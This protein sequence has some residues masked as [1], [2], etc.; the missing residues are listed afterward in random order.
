M[1]YDEALTFNEFASRP[2]YY[3]L[4]FYPD[5]NNHLLNTLLMHIAFVA[6]GQPAVGAATARLLAGVL[7]VPATYWLA[8]LL[9]GPSAAVLAAALVAASSYM[10]EYS[11]NA[12]GYTL[13]ALCFVMLA[14]VG[15][16]GARGDSLL[17][18]CWRA[19]GALGA[20]A[21]P[22]MLYG[23]V[24]RRRLGCFDAAHL[25]RGTLVASG[26]V[27]GLVSILAV[28]AGADHLGPDKLAA[29]RFVVPLALGGVPAELARLAGSTWAF[30]NRDVPLAAG[31]AAAV[32]LL[33]HG[34]SSSCAAL[35]AA[36]L[37]APLVCLAAG[38]SFSASRR[39]S[40]C[41]CFCCRSISRS[42][43]AGLARFVD[44]RLL[45]LVFGA[46]LGYIMLSSG[47][48]LRSTETGAFPDAE[49]VTRTLAPRLA[50]D[51][52]VMT[53]LPASLPELQYYFPRAGLPTSVLVRAPDDAQ[54]VWVIA[55]PG[56]AP[57]PTAA[58]PT[59]IE[60][61]RFPSA[62]L[63]ELKAPC[64][65]ALTASSTFSRHVGLR[66]AR[67]RLAA[68]VGPQQRHLVRV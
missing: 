20:Y 38:C 4:S 6:A 29:N 43:A 55:A 67:K 32:R 50:P 1:R 22:T 35:R 48:I 2:L 46:V 12:R 13:Q 18:C 56:S 30:W 63:F 37:A 40:A 53:Q 42:P 14:L 58:W 28:P 62:T 52:A 61:Q 47:S 21:V 7:L 31:R 24:D 36:G 9:Y 57:A 64:S 59:V 17:R 60:V 45:G 23:V 15:R 33:R 68:T 54:N 16:G 65:S 49:A 25:A 39:S 19:G 41:G 27:L 5:P 66:H 8:R 26:L 44:G 11:T 3:G 10:V 51:D 34:R